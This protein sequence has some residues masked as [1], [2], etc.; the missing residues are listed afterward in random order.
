[1]SD[2]PLW[3]VAM[4]RPT[5]FFVTLL[6]FLCS[7]FLLTAKWERT[8]GQIF[9]KKSALAGDTNYAQQEWLAGNPDGVKVSV[10]SQL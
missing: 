5:Y 1:M 4:H 8:R 3:R 9:A 7:S 10:K 2:D 6:L